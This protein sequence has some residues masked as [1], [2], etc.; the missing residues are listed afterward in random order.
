MNYTLEKIYKSGLKFLTPLN[1]EE[2]YQFVITEAIKLVKADYGSIL[3]LQNNELKRVYASSE[4][5]YK[6]KP[7]KRDFMYQVLKTR[8]PIVLNIKQVAQHHPEIKETLIRSDIILPLLDHQKPVGIIT[9]MSLKDKYFTKK[10]IGI[11]KMFAPLAMLAI[12]KAQ[13]HD[14]TNKALQARNMFISMAAH[15]L[16]TPLTTI[17]GYAQLLYSKLAKTD[18]P[19]SRWVDQLRW[20]SYR[21]NQLVNELLEIEHIKTGK[22]QYVWK[23]CCLREIVDRALLDFRF[24]RPH[25]SVIVKNRLTPGTD[26]VIGDFNKLLQAVINLLDNAAKFSPA[27]KEVIIGLRRKSGNIILE[28][29]DQGKGI[30][31]K[32]L[33]RLFEIF[34]RGKDNTTEGM[35]IGLFLTKNIIAQHHGEVRIKSKEA[36]G[37]TIEVRLP[38]L[39]I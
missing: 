19:E 17:N 8:K 26:R 30:A 15:E 9:I 4:I 24:T 16:K 34:Y 31:K 1:L 27:D 25:T 35:G 12:R 36:R 11:L 14:E 7:R 6:I 28:V 23:E 10:E 38:E 29:K 33:P 32:D 18:T 37:T 20:E 3:L 21:L 2:T 13:L 22:F 5:F 39:K